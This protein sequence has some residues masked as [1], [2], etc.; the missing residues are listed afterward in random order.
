[1]SDT[2]DCPQDYPEDEEELSECCTA[3]IIHGD[4]CSKC[5]EHI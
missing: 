1:M 3:P 5:L 4:L 2:T